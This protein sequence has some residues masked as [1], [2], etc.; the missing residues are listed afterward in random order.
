MPHELDVT[1][2]IASFAGRDPA[3]HKLGVAVGR[4]MTAE[5]AMTL[6][7][8]GGWNVRKV[9]LQVAPQFGVE[10]ADGVPEYL[11]P[12]IEV[13]D[14][15]ATVR[16]NPIT[17][18]TEYLG[19]VGNIY[20]PIQ[21]E[22][23][24]D[25]L[26]GLV[27]ESG[28]HFETAGALRDGRETFVTMKLPQ[29]MDL[30]TPSGAIDRT[31]FYL[32]GLN[33]HDGQGAYRLMV[34]PVRIVCANTQGAAIRAA[35]SSWTIRHTV[36]SK[37]ALEEMRRSLGLTF[38]Y[39]GAFEDEMQKLMD[40]PMPE[41]ATERLLDELFDVE[42][43]ATARQ[44]DHRRSLVA[45]AEAFLASAANETIV[46]TAYGFYNAVTEF[47]DHGWNEGQGV[48][49]ERQLRGSFADLKSRTFNL[50]A[51]FARAN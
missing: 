46:G 24:C 18:S 8:L 37:G 39:I 19:V 30:M 12:A 1:D 28:A 51:E 41:V 29:H 15:F 13:P 50:A 48:A 16:T 35:V 4:A 31:E 23:T 32:A 26:N 20:Q 43:A 42:G 27:D 22:E 44:E 38:K 9:A 6:S 14:K 33:S 7:H 3:W 47:V 21:N 5:E 11:E 25:L 17:G 34:T 2:G 49:P 40:T 36:G 10:D 45:G